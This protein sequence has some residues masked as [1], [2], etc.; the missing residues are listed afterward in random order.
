MTLI[1]G[2]GHIDC[3]PISLL[4]FASEVLTLAWNKREWESFLISLGWGLFHSQMT[5][6]VKPQ[7]FVPAVLNIRPR[8]VPCTQQVFIPYVKE[9]MIEINQYILSTW[10]IATRLGS[11]YTVLALRSSTLF[12][13]SILS[14][15]TKQKLKT[16]KITC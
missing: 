12:F 15:A 10:S 9:W 13:L 3:K 5:A 2:L 8:T 7:V 6:I 4:F 11:I 16:Q 14:G 1:S